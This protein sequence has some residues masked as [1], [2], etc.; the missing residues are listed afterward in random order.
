MRIKDISLE[1]ISVILV[2]ETTLDYDWGG[3]CGAGRKVKRFEGK[4][5][6][7]MRFMIFIWAKVSF[8]LSYCTLSIHA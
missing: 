5:P 1:A 2:V 6:L 8:C 7:Y 3:G 4:K